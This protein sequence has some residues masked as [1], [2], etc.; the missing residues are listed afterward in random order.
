MKKLSL[1]LI[2]IFMSIY[3]Y[4]QKVQLAGRVNN[5]LGFDY[6]YVDYYGGQVGFS[7]GGGI[8]VELGANTEIFKNLHLLTT[9]G[10]QLNL[11]L[12]YEN[13]NGTS[14]KSSLKFDRKFISIGM[15]KVFELENT[16]LSGITVG[17]GANL[18]FPGKFK[19]TENNQKLGSISFDPSL[20]YYAELGFQIGLIE[21]I[22]LYPNLRYRNLN[23]KANSY[24][25][26][27]LNNLPVR[28][29]TLNANG[30]EF[31]LTIVKRLL[32]KES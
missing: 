11:G 15:V 32:T 8:G 19:R 3:S 14:T 18:N 24:S 17:A 12:Q 25:E 10:Y 2:S 20:G 21:S 30:I 27:S 13:I 6:R 4:G 31:G 22:Y 29:Q 1:F 9:I 5:G 23:F 7:P 16:F 26:G 28:M